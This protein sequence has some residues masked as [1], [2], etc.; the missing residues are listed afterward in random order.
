MLSLTCH[1]AICPLFIRRE[2]TTVSRIHG[3]GISAAVADAAG[4][5][6][7]GSAWGTWGRSDLCQQAP[8]CPGRSCCPMC[9][10][11]ALRPSSQ[12]L[13]TSLAGALVHGWHGLEDSV[14]LQHGNPRLVSAAAMHQLPMQAT[15]VGDT[16]LW[17]SAR[18]YVTKAADS[19]GVALGGLALPWLFAGMMLHDDT[20]SGEP[21][22]A[23]R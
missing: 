6:P 22:A 12:H 1:Q 4:S 19:E 18:G 20:H 21:A 17:P 7:G 13:S 8:L 15:C 9:W 16:L 2:L 11:L 23:V 5:A 3:G 10:S 14:V